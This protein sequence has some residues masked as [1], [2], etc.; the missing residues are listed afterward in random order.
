M[1]HLLRGLEATFWV[2]RSGEN[3]LFSQE[4]ESLHTFWEKKSEF[5][6]NACF[7]LMVFKIKR[8]SSIPSAFVRQTT[9]RHES[10]PITHMYAST[11]AT[12]PER[13]V[14]RVFG[15]L[16]FPTKQGRVEV[17]LSRLAFGRIHLP[18]I[19]T[20]SFENLFPLFL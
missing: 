20:T 4:D 10:P 14:I 6:G 3:S 13:S 11:H 9:C 5:P 15:H 2:Q 16:L 8:P 7:L 1:S 18:T 12:D 17:F 19:L